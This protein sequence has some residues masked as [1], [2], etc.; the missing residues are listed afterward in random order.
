LATP[1]GFIEPGEDP[2]DA[3]KR[4][5]LEETGYEASTWISLGRFPVDANRGAGT[6]SSFLAQGARRVAEINADDLEEQELL[7]LTPEELE[8]ALLNGEFKIMPW[9]FTIAL[10]LVHLKSHA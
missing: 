3:I 2:L 4:E 10:A 9:A 8:Q 5:L 6:G 1:G 7:S